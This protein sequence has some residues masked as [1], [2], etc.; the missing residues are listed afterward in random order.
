MKEYVQFENFRNLD[1]HYKNPNRI[2]TMC[3]NPLYDDYDYCEE[4]KDHTT[5]KVP[6]PECEGTG[7]ISYVRKESFASQ[8]ISP[9]ICEFYCDCDEGWIEE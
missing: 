4:C 2:C 9:F 1:D 5:A 3:G 8:R 6:C 7:K